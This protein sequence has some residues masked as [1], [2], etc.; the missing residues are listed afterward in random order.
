MKSSDDQMVQQPADDIPISE[1]KATMFQA[2]AHAPRIRILE[3]L[4]AGERSVGELQPLVGIES[5]HLSQQLGVLKRAGL[6]TS[7]KEGQSVFYSLRDPLIADLLA[8]AKQ[9]LIRSLSETR[10]L[11]A[12]LGAERRR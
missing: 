4:A 2:M 3:T 10:D 5:S 1:L 6:V 7:R 9:F 8:V 12:G 11:L